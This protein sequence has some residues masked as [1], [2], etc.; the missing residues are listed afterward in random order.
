MSIYFT[1][2]HWLGSK[3]FT[4]IARD[5]IRFMTRREYI[6]IAGPFWE[7]QTLISLKLSLSFPPEWTRTQ[8]MSPGPIFPFS[9]SS[10]IFFT[11]TLKTAYSSFPP[12]IFT[13]SHYCQ[14]TSAS[15]LTFNL[16]HVPPGLLPP[17][18][19]AC[20][21][22]YLI[23]LGLFW[24]FFPLLLCCLNFHFSL[25]VSSWLLLTSWI[26]PFPPMWTFH[27]SL[28]TLEIN[29]FI[30]L[31]LYSRKVWVSAI[32]QH[33]TLDLHKSNIMHWSTVLSNHLGTS[34]HTA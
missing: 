30:M 2:K 1:I 19:T 29:K 26:L 16:L 22:S 12:W 34:S 23:Y 13:C 11:D 17:A 8:V 9:L 27:P 6:D 3:G 20:V 5:H 24:S 25:L 33:V 15:H 21:R 28:S 7:V 31:L 4:D 14:S 18:T 32:A 10:V